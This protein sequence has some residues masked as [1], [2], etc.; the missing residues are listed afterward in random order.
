ML[1]YDRWKQTVLEETITKGK[2]VLEKKYEQEA[3]E[4]NKKAEEKIAKQ[5]EYTKNFINNHKIEDKV[6]IKGTLIRTNLPRYL[7][8]GI[9]TI[10]GFTNRGNVKCMWDADTTFSI[11]PCLLKDT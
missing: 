4:N 8:G 6:R 7:E 5:K 3:L 10:V 1:L 2:K 11:S 9:L